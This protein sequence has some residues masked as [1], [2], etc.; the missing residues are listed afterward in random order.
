MEREEIGREK[1]GVS[2]KHAGCTGFHGSGA[3]AWL[4]EQA[5]VPKTVQGT[6][7]EHLPALANFRAD[8]R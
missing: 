7:F 1:R 6:E 8:R 3:A 5:A 2:F 4:P